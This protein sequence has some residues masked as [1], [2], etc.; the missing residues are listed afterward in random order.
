MLSQ[1]DDTATEI[2]TFPVF[3]RRWNWFQT[4]VQSAI[5][6]VIAA[7]LAGLFG[8]GPLAHAERAV[9]DTPIVLRYDRFLRAGLP[10]QM[11]VAITRPLDAEHLDG[12]H[13]AIGLNAAFLEHVSVTA[14]QPR[15]EA[16]DATPGGVT[17]RFRLGPERRGDITLM[18]S[19]RE[20]GTVAARVSALG[21]PVDLPLLIYP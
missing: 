16:V 8:D 18:L 20:A 11:R 7:G 1:S 2:R 19:P 14:T 9:P 10:S 15:A 3:E 21:R 13:L 6:V 12:E 17:Y 4:G 5:G